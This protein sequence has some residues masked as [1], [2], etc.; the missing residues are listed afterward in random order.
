[1]NLKKILRDLKNITS[2]N[3]RSIQEKYNHFESDVNKFKGN[4][5]EDYSKKFFIKMRICTQYWK[6]PSETPMNIIKMLGI[7]TVDNGV[8]AIA[9]CDGKYYLIQVKYRQDEL[10]KIGEIQNAIYEASKKNTPL[11]IFTNA[12]F[13]TDIKNITVYNKSKIL[14]VLKMDNYYPSELYNCDNEFI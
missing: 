1:M 12:N 14:E 5:F 8:D 7:K 4:V 9:L 13:V 10:L 6:H 2:E 11:I 3:F